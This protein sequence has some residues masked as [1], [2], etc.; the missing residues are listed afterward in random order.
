M[1][2]SVRFLQSNHMFAS[3]T[4]VYRN[5]YNFHVNLREESAAS[6]FTFL[7]LGSFYIVLGDYV[8]DRYRSAIKVKKNK[9]GRLQV[10]NASN[11]KSTVT[12]LVYIHQSSNYCVENNSL[13]ILGE[14]IRTY[15]RFSEAIQ[16]NVMVTLF[17]Y[18]E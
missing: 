18:R 10:R 5:R 4:R 14:F 17:R 12:D 6:F 7:L 2:W 16:S 9:K 13:G 8:T 3:A 1:S 11:K 15:T